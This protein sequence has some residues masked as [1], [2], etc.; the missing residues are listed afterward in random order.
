MGKRSFQE[1]E[2]HTLVQMTFKGG[3]PRSQAS[4]WHLV[5][6][7][8]RQIGRARDSARARAGGG[9]SESFDSVVRSSSS[10]LLVDQA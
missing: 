1:P 9:S 10:V 5:S 8:P 3:S 6:E 7:E 4:T 2:V